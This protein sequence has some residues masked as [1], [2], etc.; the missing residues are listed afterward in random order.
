VGFTLNFKKVKKGIIYIFMN[1]DI[2]YQY[3]KCKIFYMIN[4]QQSIINIITIY[5]MENFTFFLER[6][7]FLT[8][9]TI[10]I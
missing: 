2:N 8:I 4:I 7:F 9:L 3:K 5:Y 1:N 10:M 6:F